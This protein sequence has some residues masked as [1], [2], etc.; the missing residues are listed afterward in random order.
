MHLNEAVHIPN[1]HAR[2]RT[3]AARI[4][5]GLHTTN[6]LDLAGVDS[7]PINGVPGHEVSPHL[8]VDPDR[9]EKR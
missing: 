3:V 7:P 9:G 2:K 1:G 8:V 6:G 5:P 4:G